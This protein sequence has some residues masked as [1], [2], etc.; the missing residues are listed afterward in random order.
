MQ[1][2]TKKLYKVTLWSTDVDSSFNIELT[3][4][5]FELLKDIERATNTGEITNSLTVKLA[6]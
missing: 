3:Q 2:L 1:K 6:K 5:E 4:K